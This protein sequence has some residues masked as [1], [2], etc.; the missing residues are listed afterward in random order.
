MTPEEKARQEID[1][2]LEMAGWAVQDYCDFS[3]GA[4]L[5]V[6]VR[7]FPL[8][9]GFADYLLFIDYEAVGAIEA[10]P[11]GT[12]LSGVEEQTGGYLFGLPEEMAHSRD[13]LP[14]G[15]ESTGQR[16]LLCGHQRH[17][18]SLTQGLCLPQAGDPPGLSRPGEGA[19]RE[20]G[21]AARSG[22]GQSQGVPVRGYCEP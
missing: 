19:A 6:A 21:G 15:Y 8:R 7:E 3:L 22:G 9:P 11:E 2:L 17:H 1:R 4:S 12:T 5:G 13:P 20:A 16:D 10:K 14:F 18:P